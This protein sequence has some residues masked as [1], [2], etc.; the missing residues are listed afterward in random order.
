MKFLI[1]FFII[2]LRQRGIEPPKDKPTDLQSAAITILPLP[3]CL[4]QEL[5]P[6]FM[7]Y[8]TNTLPI[9]LKRF[10]IFLGGKGFEPMFLMEDS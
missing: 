7:V 4:L 9:K 10:K 8:K 3:Q 1:L 2:I 6:H 5:N